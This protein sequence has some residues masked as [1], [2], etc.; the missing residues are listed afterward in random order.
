[1]K[2]NEWK[3]KNLLY[4]MQKIIFKVFINIKLFLKLLSIFDINFSFLDIV[5]EQ[6]YLCMVDGNQL[7]DEKTR[8]FILSEIEKTMLELRA[9]QKEE[10]EIN[11]KNASIPNYVKYCEYFAIFIDLVI[12]NWP[13]Y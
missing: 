6:I 9:E 7:R 12:H 4:K 10:A 3:E 8:Q 11:E 2:K 13:F 1:M 5:F